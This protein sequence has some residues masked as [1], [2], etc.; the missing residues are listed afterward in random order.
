MTSNHM[1]DNILLHLSEK[2]I[3]AVR[4]ID[5]PLLILAGAG[6]GKTRVLTNKAAWLIS[7][8][9]TEPQYITAVT[10]TNKAA[11]EMRTRIDDMI[12]STSAAKRIQVSTFHGYGLRFIFRYLDSSARKILN[13]R[14]GFTVFD[15]EDSRA[16][17]KDILDDVNAEEDMTPAEILDIVSKD[18]ILW[19][20]FPHDDFIK[21]EWLRD[22]ADTYRSRLRELNAVDFDDLMIL[23]LQVMERF[24]DITR[25]EQNRIK[26]LLVDEYQDVNKAQALLL[27][28]YLVGKN[29][30]I[31]AVGDPDQAIYGWRGADINVI[32][33]FTNEYPKSKIIKLE[34]NYR[35]TKIILDASNAL[36]RNN[37]HRLKKTL[38]T[39]NQTGV[40]IHTLLA[41]SDIQ[42]AD[43]LVQEV[44]RLHNV[45]HFA[46][47]DIAVLY[48][49]NSMS[50]LIEK[51]FLESAVPYKIIRGVS[52]YD[53]MEVKD[54]LAILKL[55]LN[56]ADILS[57]GRAVKIRGLIEGMGPKALASWNVWIS[58]Q[59]AGVLDN[60]LQFWASVE[61]G[62]WK[63]STKKAR[64]SMQ[65]FAGH[66][67]RLHEISD[68]G[69]R[70]AVDYVLHDMGYAGHL[71]NYD[72]ASYNDRLDNVMELKS[73]VPDGDLRETLA[74][75]ALFTDADTAGDSDEDF[76]NL[77]TLHASKG[78]EFPAVFMVGLEE[79]IFPHYIRED[80]EDPEAELEEER[81]LC[82]VGMT[83]AEEK[84]YMTSARSRMLYGSVKDC[85]ISRFLL[86]IPDE[87]KE[88]DDRVIFSRSA[89]GSRRDFGRGKYGG[90]GNN[91]RRRFW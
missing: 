34:Q 89:F 5:G 75:A 8:G 56:P 78:L 29:C 45:R 46:Y 27:R 14:Q 24:P 87:C 70:G 4:Y 11:G 43:F 68:E 82:Y 65:K 84:L 81:R 71:M 36:I 23:P 15:R 80:C 21:D 73:I 13:L 16:L 52:F 6:S 72:I 79:G 48:R 9:I 53:R 91:G 90:Y 51:K 39:A 88:M 22:I 31:N 58:E 83:R 3:E 74:E 19:S 7:E 40:K 62:E 42:E 61:A 69:I 86:E 18:Y 35:S 28:R 30:T 67:R 76:V 38:Y 77:M 60:P 2:Q 63:G 12:G 32:L 37:K 10:F 17:I 49:Q 47:R 26:W 54:V 66:M 20:P 85:E 50:R 33:N 41:A 57:L 1:N 64:E 59:T 25:H 44:E 55:S